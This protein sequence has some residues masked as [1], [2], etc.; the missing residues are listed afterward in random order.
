VKKRALPGE[1]GIRFMPV[2]SIRKLEARAGDAEDVARY[3]VAFS[4]EF[5]V[6]RQGWFG[7]Y[8]EVLDHS[9]GAVDM[10]R[11]ESGTAAVLE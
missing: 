3:E 6:E 2:Q 10:T 8:R 11:F 9:P 5:E 4:S 7:T 1:P